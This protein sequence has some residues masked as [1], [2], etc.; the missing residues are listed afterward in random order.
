MQMPHKQEAPGEDT[1]SRTC[2]PP[3]P[4]DAS[5]EQRLDEI[6]NRAVDDFAQWLE[7]FKQELAS[8]R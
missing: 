8:Q 2:R 1:D 4:A 5:A 6:T 7:A 3:H